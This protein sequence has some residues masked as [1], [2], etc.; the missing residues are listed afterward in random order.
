MKKKLVLLTLSLLMAIGVYADI[1]VTGTVT[2]KDE[3]DE[4]A[5][6]ATVMIKGKPKTAVA[7]DIDGNFKITVPNEKTI[8]QVSYVGLSL[9]PISEPTRHLRIE[10]AVVC[11]KKKWGGGG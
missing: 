2:F 1:V 9:I 5:I 8:I 6:G 7:V 3:P 4:P 11:L 10:Y